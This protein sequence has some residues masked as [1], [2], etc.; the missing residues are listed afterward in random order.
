[1]IKT[2]D[3]LFAGAGASTTL[4]LMSME[5]RGLLKNKSIVIIDPDDKTKNDKTYCFWAKED[6]L[7]TIDCN[8]L[9]SYRWNK[10]IVN[11]NIQESIYPLEYLHI[12]GHEV[13]KELKRIIQQYNILRVNDTVK[14][15]Q[16]TEDG[17]H[18]FTNENEFYSNLVFDSRPPSYQ[19]K[20]S[21]QYQLSQ[22]FI[23]YVVETESEIPMY[24]SVRLM[25]FEVDQLNHTQFMYVLPFESNKALI[26]ITRFGSEKITQIEAEQ[27]LDHYIQNNFGKYKI[28][29]IEKGCIP[30]SN[31]E[32]LN[33]E[34]ENVIPIGARAGA[35]KA[36]T[37]YAFTKMHEHAEQITKSLHQKEINININHKIKFKFY[38]R[39]L[40]QILK[41][42]ADKGKVIFKTLF[43]KNKAVEVLHFIEEKTSLKDDIKILLSLP[44]KPF[45]KALFFDTLNKLKTIALPLLLLLFTILL[46]ILKTE[47]FESFNAVQMIFFALGLFIVGI[48]HGAVDNIVETK[49]INDG[50]RISF[51]IQY[52][53]KALVYFILWLILPSIALV[54]FIIYSAWHFGQSDMQEWFPNKKNNIRNITWGILLL[55]IILLGHVNETNSILTNI[56]T[57]TIP[58][59]EELGFILAIALSAFSITWSIYERKTS[60]LLS[61]ITLTAS[62][63][64]PLISAFGIYFIGQH[65]ITGWKHLTI[66]LKSNNISLFKKALPYNLGA[67][68]LFSLLLVNYNN[69]WLSSFFILISCISLPHVLVMH[70]FYNESI[71]K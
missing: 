34:I 27:I 11:K 22:S 44:I 56:K 46:I 28:I 21:N 36:S 48:P 40:L 9:I 53:S 52:L 70:R 61:V 67:W 60:M 32:I 33:E 20:S 42:Q 15:I 3:Y 13:Y 17:L 57:I 7:I 16:E 50:I 29:D 66:K 62:I 35:I 45:I 30:M 23:G 64:L 55:S 14:S 63:Y 8:H 24:D 43:E 38:D 4:I 2:F 1:M 49:N 26:E 25:D 54:F 69:F 71:L 65:S 47:N 39:L 51:I 18:V 37:G 41:H 19:I 6:D 58:V 68:L 10:I 12:T 31:A 5:K 59:S